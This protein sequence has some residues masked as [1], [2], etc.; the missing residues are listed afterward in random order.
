MFNTVHYGRMVR[1]YRE[2]KNLTIEETAE[3]CGI[4]PTGL[5][6]IELGISNP[7]LSTVLKIADV[8]GMDIGILNSC[9][10]VIGALFR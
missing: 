8:L 7:K 4:S 3:K 9:V 6:K 5:D 1:H 2:R 10:R